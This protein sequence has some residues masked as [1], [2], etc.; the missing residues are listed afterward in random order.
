MPKWAKDTCQKHATT[1]NLGQGACQAIEDAVVLADCIRRVQP[2]EA[3][4]R[5]YERHRIP[6]TAMIVRI[7]WQS[8]RILQLDG[9]ALETLRNW[10]MGTLVGRHFAL[11][12]L[13]NLL[14]YRVP[15]LQK[16]V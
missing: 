12:M 15:T 14:T 4:L 7:S 1:P 6:R 9:P 11:R 5:E 3:A 2:V 16:P 13:Q 8:G 10:F